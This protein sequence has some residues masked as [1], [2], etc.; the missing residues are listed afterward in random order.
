MYSKV[1]FKSYLESKGDNILN[2]NKHIYKR[3]LK[4][5]LV[6]YSLFK[7]N[8]KK[9]RKRFRSILKCNIAQKRK[10][11]A[12]NYHK[13]KSVSFLITECKS[14]AIYTHKKWD[15]HVMSGDLCDNFKY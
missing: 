9:R 14:T 3:T 8:K 6:Y 15:K 5:P 1:K 13:R 11:K 2:L 4:A 12:Y 7:K 10:L